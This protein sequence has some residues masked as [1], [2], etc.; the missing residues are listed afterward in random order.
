VVVG[1][2]AQAF[3]SIEPGLVSALTLRGIDARVLAGESKIFGQ[4][5]VGDA[6]IR[7]WVYVLSGPGA[8]AAPSGTTLVARYDPS[9][10]VARGFA[11]AGVSGVA[12][13]IAVY[14]GAPDD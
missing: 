10:D 7:T 8:D 2:G 11:N 5:R 14:V 13:P 1:R 4:R 3:T 12:E 9:V 6:A